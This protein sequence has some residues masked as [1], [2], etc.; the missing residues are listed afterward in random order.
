MAIVVLAEGRADQ[1]SH[2]LRHG[3]L[4]FESVSPL[5]VLVRFFGF[6]F[7]LSLFLLVWV[8]GWVRVCWLEGGGVSFLFSSAFLLCLLLLLTFSMKLCSG[9]IKPREITA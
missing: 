4:R 5:V 7:F 6:S 2:D 8:G 9:R 3:V 1:E